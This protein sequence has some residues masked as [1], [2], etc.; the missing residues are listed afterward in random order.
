MKPKYRRYN[1]DLV[2]LIKDHFTIGSRVVLNHMDDEQAPPLGIKGTVF[3][4]DDLGTVHVNW[5]NGSTLGAV[6]LDGDSISIIKEASNGSD[7]S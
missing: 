4:V 3:C 5:D 2:R 1:R 6:I 7:E